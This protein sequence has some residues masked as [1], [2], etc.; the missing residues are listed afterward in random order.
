MFEMTWVDPSFIDDSASYSPKH[1]YVYWRKIVHSIDN[2]KVFG[3]WYQCHIKQHVC[4]VLLNTGVNG[5]E[6][7]VMSISLNN[8]ILR[9]WQSSDICG[10]NMIS[11][12]EEGHFLLKVSFRIIKTRVTDKMVEVFGASS[13]LSELPSECTNEHL[14]PHIKL[15]F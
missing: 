14:G 15:N 5:K 10:R 4:S 6:D 8:I 12:S 9:S 2:L 3:I 13:H 1:K 11:E 7:V